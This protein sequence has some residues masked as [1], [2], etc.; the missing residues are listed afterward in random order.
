MPFAQDTED[1]QCHNPTPIT[2]SCGTALGGSK[3]P[4]EQLTALPERNDEYV[5][6]DD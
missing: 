6:R 1:V 3:P 2:S 4:S 5:L